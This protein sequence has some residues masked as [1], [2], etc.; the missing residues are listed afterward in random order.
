MVGNIGR[1]LGVNNYFC[2]RKSGYS[3]I[4]WLWGEVFRKIIKEENNFKF[5]SL[6]NRIVNSYNWVK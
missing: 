2:G 1:S 6:G 4:K 3:R 5:L